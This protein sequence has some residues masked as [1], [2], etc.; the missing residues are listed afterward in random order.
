M[1]P[2]AR[3]AGLRC[4]GVISV[5]FGCPYEGHVEPERVF[6]IAERLIA[7]GAEEIGFGDTTG[8]ANPL[9]VRRVLRGGA[10]SGSAAAPS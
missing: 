6:A 5:S 4:E 3:A 10:S 9:Q 7:A 8:M 1:L 2:R